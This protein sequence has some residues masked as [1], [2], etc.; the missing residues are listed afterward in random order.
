MSTGQYLHK[1]HNTRYK[2]SGNVHQSICTQR[3]HNED[4]S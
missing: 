3:D 4:G 1:S 2:H